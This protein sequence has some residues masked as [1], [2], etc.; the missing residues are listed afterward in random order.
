MC[1]SLL[2][3]N[4][5]LLFHLFCRQRPHPAVAVSTGAV[6]RQ[7]LPVLHQLDGRRLGIQALWPRWGERPR[8]CRSLLHVLGGPEWLAR[9]TRCLRT[10]LKKNLKM[11]MPC[12]NSGRVNASDFALVLFNLRM[13]MVTY[14]DAQDRKNKQKKQSFD[15]KPKTEYYFLTVNESSWQAYSFKFFFSPP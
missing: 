1:K 14:S 10:L 13:W 8:P 6:D 15:L 7:V 11:C 12:F 5:H 9:W 4:M 3:L 2:V